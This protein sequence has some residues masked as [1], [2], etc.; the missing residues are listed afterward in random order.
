MFNKID[1]IQKKKYVIDKTEY[2]YFEPATIL[3]KAITNSKT[4]LKFSISDELVTYSTSYSY[5]FVLSTHRSGSLIDQS[6]PALD[7][8]QQRLVVEPVFDTERGRLPFPSVKISEFMGFL[9]D[10]MC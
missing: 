5:E 4:F 2:I 9:A 10:S 8:L 1:K 7:S 6:R 3:S